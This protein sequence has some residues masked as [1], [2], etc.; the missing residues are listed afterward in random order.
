MKKFLS[1]LFVVAF[2]IS[3]AACGNDNKQSAPE[4]STSMAEQ[5]ESKKEAPKEDP[6]A[7]ADQKNAVKKLV[8]MPKM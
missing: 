5:T 1:I 7:T 2:A 8:A 4:S 6:N 3:V